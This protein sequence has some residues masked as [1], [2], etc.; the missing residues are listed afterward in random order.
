MQWLKKQ[1]RCRPFERRE[2]LRKGD[3]SGFE[4]AVQR[5]R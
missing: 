2:R 4:R 3:F 1:R 5:S